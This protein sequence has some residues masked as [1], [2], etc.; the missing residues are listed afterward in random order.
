MC[1]SGASKFKGQSS[2]VYNDKKVKTL[3]H[4]VELHNYEHL[5]NW[6]VFAYLWSTANVII[7]RFLET[8][9]RKIICEYILLIYQV[10]GH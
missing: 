7:T 8:W 4:R 6:S 3:A 1:I 5:E 9:T 2:D 10:P